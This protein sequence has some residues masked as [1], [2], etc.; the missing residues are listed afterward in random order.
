MTVPNDDLQYPIAV[1][2]Y[3]SEI[4]RLY[5]RQSLYVGFQLAAIA[6]FI[7]S[8]DKLAA[9]PVVMR[10]AIGLML[11][12]AILT[13]LVTC[14]GLH[15]HQTLLKVIA[16]LEARSG[17]RLDLLKLGHSHS[18]LPIQLNYYYAIIMNLAL[19]ATWVLLLVTQS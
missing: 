4:D 15:S 19:V 7:A 17:G 3:N 8:L 10:I 13:T 12:L 2:L 1:S 14:R 5:A 18:R 9:Q 6:G 11:V 16:T